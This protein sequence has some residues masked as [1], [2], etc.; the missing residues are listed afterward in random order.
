[1]VEL[2]KITLDSG[3]TDLKIEFPLP[4]VACNIMIEYSEYSGKNPSRPC[5]P[6]NNNISTTAGCGGKRVPVPVPVPC[7]AVDQ[8]GCPSPPPALRKKD[9]E[10]SSSLKDDNKMELHVTN[11]IISLD[12]PVKDIYTKIWLPEA[13]EGEAMRVV[14]TRRTERSGRRRSRTSWL[15]SWETVGA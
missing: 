14:S 11:K 2:K 6:H 1:M 15:P 7:C 13:G 3:Q 4:I 12:L 9:R 10:K 8:S 5:P